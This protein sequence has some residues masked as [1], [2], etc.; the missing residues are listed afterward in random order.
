MVISFHQTA[1]Q[2]RPAIRHNL[3]IGRNRRI[4]DGAKIGGC[5]LLDVV[6][7]HRPAALD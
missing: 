7:N 2:G 5:D 1:A 4:N 6:R 3:S